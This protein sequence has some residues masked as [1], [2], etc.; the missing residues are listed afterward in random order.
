[1]DRISTNLPNDNMYYHTS[2]RLAEMNN[3]QNQIA[4]QSRLQFLRDDPLAASH[5]VRYD[6]L[7]FRTERYGENAEAAMLS[8]RLVESSMQQQVEV[9]QRARE[10]AVQ[11]ATGTYSES[12]LQ[13]MSQ[14][15]NELINHALS[16]A[17]GKNSE[18]QFM[19]AGHRSGSEPFRVTT[20][21]APDGRRGAVVGVDY[22]GDIG[23]REVEVGEGTLVQTSVPGS[24]VF[25]AGTHMVRGGQDVEGYVAAQDSSFT[26]DGVTIDVKAGETMGNILDSINSSEAAVKASLD[27]VEGKLVLETT[28]PHQLWLGDSTGTLLQDLG[29]ISGSGRPPEN[30]ALDAEQTGQSLFDV[31]ISLRDNLSK[32]D[33]QSIGSKDLGNLDQAMNSVLTNVAAMGARSNRLELAMKQAEKDSVD[34]TALYSAE[35]DIDITEAVTQLKALEVTHRAALAATAK[36]AQPTLLDYLR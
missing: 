31:L 32:G 29:V 19:F 22:L 18:G 4:S 17:N 10:L 7:N 34:I 27:P 1:M 8:T 16:V 13:M 36:V 21:T 3:V 20:G 26:I 28:R 12:D 2:R 11:G 14:E 35:T 33:G 9:L 6:S 15:V 24:E 25:W 5:A 23:K 30:L